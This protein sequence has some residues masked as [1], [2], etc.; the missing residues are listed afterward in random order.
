M[1]YLGID[2]AVEKHDLCLLADDGRV[3]SEF[4]IA[5]DSRRFQKLRELLENLEDVAVDIER[6]DGLL[7]DWLA[8]Q[9]R[10]VYVTT[11]L[12]VGQRVSLGED[13]VARVVNKYA[14]WARLKSVTPHVLR[15]TFSYAY[16]GRTQNDLVGLAD[17]LAMT[18]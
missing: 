5:T 12:F 8:A 4:S 6:G 15:H 16:L 3:L 7:V 1:H 18:T 2:W 10:D 11:P 13:A 14:A 9:P 17:I